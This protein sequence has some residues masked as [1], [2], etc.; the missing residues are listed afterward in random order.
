MEEA[1][2]RY[3]GGSSKTWRKWVKDDLDMLGLHPYI[4]KAKKLKFKKRKSIN[5]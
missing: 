3:E 2:V 4:L 1:A 5:S